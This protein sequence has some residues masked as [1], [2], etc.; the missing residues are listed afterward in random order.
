[1]KSEKKEEGNLKLLIRSLRT[2]KYEKYK[3]QGDSLSVVPRETSK[4]DK[5]RQ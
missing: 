1:M 2:K 3:I 4:E 5:P